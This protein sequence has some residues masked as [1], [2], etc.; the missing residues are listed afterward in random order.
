MS[1]SKCPIVD[2]LVWWNVHIYKPVFQYDAH[3]NIESKKYYSQRRKCSKCYIISIEPFLIYQQRFL[4]W[5]FE[6]QCFAILKVFFQQG[7]SLSSWPT[8][9]YTTCSYTHNAVGL[10]KHNLHFTHVSLSVTCLIAL[11]HSFYM[12]HCKQTFKG[13]ISVTSRQR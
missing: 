3:K 2:K 11:M 10:F 8:C 9:T 12:Q 1:G 5:V 13:M 4:F 6:Y 7:N